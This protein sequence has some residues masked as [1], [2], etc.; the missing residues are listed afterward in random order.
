MTDELPQP[1]LE[2]LEQ[3]RIELD[4]LRKE[5]RFLNARSDALHNQ[6]RTRMIIGCWLLVLA[7]LAF[8]IL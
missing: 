6:L 3:L 8:F 7:N 2:P 1:P 4:E 5:C